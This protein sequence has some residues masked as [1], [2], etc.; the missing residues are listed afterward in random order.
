MRFGVPAETRGNETCVAM[1]PETAK[2]LE[3]MVKAIE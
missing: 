3:A 1:T 2:M